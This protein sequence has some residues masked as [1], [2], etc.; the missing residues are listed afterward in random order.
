MAW[1]IALC[2][3]VVLVYGYTAWMLLSGA[4]GWFRRRG[5]P[6]RA[7]AAG[8]RPM[9]WLVL[10]GTTLTLAAAG[11]VC[12]V[13]AWFIEPYWAEVT[14]FEIRS[15]KLPA[16]DRPVRIVHI[17]DT[18][19]DG[20]RARLE[21]ELPGIIRQTAPDL[22]VWTGDAANDPSG[23]ERFRGLMRQ[24]SAIAPTYAVRGNWDSGSPEL[25]S[26][27]GVIVVGEIDGRPFDVEIRGAR[28]CIAGGAWNQW[29][30]TIQ[31]LQLAD[32]TRY[33]VFLN[34]LPDAILWV[35]KAVVREKDP[36]HKPDMFLA[37][38]THGGQVRLP[39]FGAVVTRQKTGRLFENGMVEY[40][41]T[42][43]HVSR[44][45]GMNGNGPRV[46]FLCRPEVA[47]IDLYSSKGDGEIVPSGSR[48]ASH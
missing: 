32:P 41:G 21:N 30:Y 38:H 10:R 15:D 16:N 36:A 48:E 18:H 13:N 44:G 24:L 43:V 47:V 14:H 11:A 31:S 9:V 19:C 39:F 40:N 17:S 29:R 20:D 46:R 34:H 4:V 5:R 27:T 28:L 26:G 22:I 1:L 37:G 45:I 3:L 23:H 33:I 6:A 2:G 7:K 8:R 35:D 42:M 12:I 25:F